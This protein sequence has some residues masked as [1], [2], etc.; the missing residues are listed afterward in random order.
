MGEPTSY[1][2][3]SRLMRG[4]RLA[5][6]AITVAV[7]FGFALPLLLGS[8][9]TYRSLAQQV[10]AFTLLT[11][12]AVVAGVQILRDRPLGRPRWVMVAAV[13]AA[14]VLAT[15]GIPPAE[16]MSEEEWSYGVIGW[17]GL[18]VL[19]DYST[20]AAAVFLGA[21][22]VAS[23]GQLALVGQGHETAD[24]VV[25]AAIVLGGEL[26]VLAGAM[27]LRGLVETASTAAAAAERVRTAEAVAE[28]V[29]ADR[30][31]RYAELATTSVPL[32][33]A[34]AAGSADLAD[35]RVRADYAVAAARLRR[36]F[37][38]HDEVSD[39]LVH[40]LRACLDLAERNG[41]AVHLG[42]CGEWPTPPLAVRRALTEP[43]LRILSVAVS[44]ARVTVRGSPTSVT[45]SVLADARIGGSAGYA[46]ESTAV[47]RGGVVVT[48][49]VDGPKVWV[50]ATWQARD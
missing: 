8:P 39:P 45:V 35:E 27:A 13:C 14:A 26:P 11:A 50:E 34:L 18:L 22:T 47:D 1:V 33:A 24:L 15:T 28:H 32:L 21:H 3:A 37:A 31:G 29:H 25:V 4:L 9:E 44:R 12:V 38:E 42:T 48:R 43:A 10:V 36:L 16:L 2:M 23:F 5:T 30:R 7:L 6:L 19:M 17:F 46:A 41:V 20:R 49:L 40:E